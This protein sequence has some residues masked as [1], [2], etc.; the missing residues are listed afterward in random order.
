MLSFLHETRERIGIVGGMRSKDKLDIEVQRMPKYDNKLWTIVRLRNDDGEWIPSFE[1]LFRIV[2]AICHCEDEKYPNG[3]GRFMVRDLLR[4]CCEMLHPD[5]TMEGRWQEL[6][7]KYDIP[8]R[9]TTTTP[10]PT[11]SDS[12][13]AGGNNHDSYWESIMAA[14]PPP[15]R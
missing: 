10:A 2:Q 14:G 11:Y 6:A 12:T 5:Q 9:H 3:K 15:T 1:D 8:I 13:T 7:Q 4:D